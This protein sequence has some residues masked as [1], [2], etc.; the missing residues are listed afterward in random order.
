[1]LCF[2]WFQMIFFNQNLNENFQIFENTKQS[3]EGLPWYNVDCLKENY[4]NATFLTTF[5][6]SV[7]RNIVARMMCCHLSPF[8]CVHIC[9]FHLLEGI[10]Q[11]NTINR[12]SNTTEW[13][14]SNSEQ[15]LRALHPEPF[16][17]DRSEL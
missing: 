5:H 3:E 7:G 14:L 15:M 4:D 8:T 2:S 13:S 12:L 10:V 6:A 17:I 11:S 1:M 9:P 16:Q